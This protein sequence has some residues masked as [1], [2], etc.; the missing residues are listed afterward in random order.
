MMDWDFKISKLKIN[1]K[2]D[3]RYQ[4]RHIGTG[5]IEHNTRA[6]NI[7]VAKRHQR[8]RIKIMKIGKEEA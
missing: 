1:N 3:I 8:Q 6:E 4:N 2:T 5:N 7:A